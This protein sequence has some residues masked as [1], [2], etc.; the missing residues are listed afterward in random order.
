MAEAPEEQHTEQCQ[1]RAERERCHGD[2]A[3]PVHEPAEH[4]RGRKGRQESGGAD[5]PGTRRHGDAGH[6]VATRGLQ[7]G[8]GP[9]IAC[10][11]DWTTAVQMPRLEIG[12]IRSYL[13]SLLDKKSSSGETLAELDG[14]R[15]FAVLIVMASHS[16]V[17]AMAGQ[18]AMGVWLFFVLSAFLLTR[19]ILQRM[20]GS[21]GRVELAKYVIRRIARILPLYYVCLTVIMV[22]KGL[23]AAWLFDHFTFQ[24]ADVHFWSIP[25]EEL[26]YV[27]LPILVASVAVAAKL[28]PRIPPWAFAGVLLVV[29][30]LSFPLVGINGNGTVLP[31][32]SNVFIIG[33]FLAFLL[34]TERAR[35]LLASAR[36]KPLLDVSSLILLFWILFTAPAHLRFYERSVGVSLPELGWKH[37]SVSGLLCALLLVATLKPGTWPNRLF[38]WA[39]LRIIGVLSFGLYL[40]H[41][42][43]MMPLQTLTGLDHGGTL[44]AGML[45]ASLA[46]ALVLERVVERPFMTLGR[47]LNARFQGA[48]GSDAR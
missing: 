45:L 34:P 17:L 35:V 36:L 12:F 8:S 33:F 15:G 16:N 10:G 7:H 24:K 37:T 2:A 20:P 25:Q 39:P 27:L 11:T 5:A 14:L 41:P 48:A 40:I 28:L 31:F 4:D 13:Q 6:S 42:F 18:G 29:V 43:V 26:F 32:Y 30:E 21:L 22:W 47:R 44:F 23:G 38:S 3:R 19:I 46:L 9:E 1:R